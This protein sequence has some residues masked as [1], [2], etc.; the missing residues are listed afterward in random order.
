MLGMETSVS[1]TPLFFSSFVV[2]GP[3]GS[4]LGFLTDE[5]VDGLLREFCW[6]PHGP[7]SRIFKKSLPPILSFAFQESTVKL[8]S[9][10]TSPGAPQGL[11]V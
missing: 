8:F 7:S 6:L 3:R 2:G 1:N 9:S 10:I 4:G 11:T 5:G